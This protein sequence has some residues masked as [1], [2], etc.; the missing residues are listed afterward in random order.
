[1]MTA[2]PRSRTCRNELA[3]RQQDR[4]QLTDEAE[5]TGRTPGNAVWKLHS[6]NRRSRCRACRARHRHRSRT[7]ASTRRAVVQAR[8]TPLQ[9][10]AGYGLQGA[11][12][13]A[14]EVM[15]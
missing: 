12:L 10:A 11:V 1:M 15:R 14:A 13:E 4:V 9:R 7:N 8:I 5:A 6:H 3:T 2:S